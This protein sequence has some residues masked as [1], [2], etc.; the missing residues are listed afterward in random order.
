MKTV[1][2]AKVKTERPELHF[3]YWSG[4]GSAKRSSSSGSGS[5]RTG[6]VYGEWRG[7]RPMALEIDYGDVVMAKDH[8]GDWYWSVIRKFNYADSSS[9]GTSTSGSAASAPSGRGKG[10]ILGKK[11]QLKSLLIHFVGIG[12]EDEETIRLSEGRL[13]MV[14]RSK[15][16]AE[17]AILR[18]NGIDSEDKRIQTL[19]IDPLNKHE[20]IVMKEPSRTSKMR[21]QH[22]KSSVSLSKSPS[23]SSS[24]LASSMLSASSSRGLP[25]KERAGAIAS[26][27]ALT[28]KTRKQKRK[29]NE[30]SGNSM[31]KKKATKTKAKKKRAGRASTLNASAE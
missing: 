18:D 19:A 10:L 6:I 11:Q 24:S 23:P 27:D 20:K 3:F 25:K 30:I 2:E 1:E 21:R 9:S 14:D 26:G 31:G 15:L 16:Q 12:I 22:V 5:T 8:Q 17:C 28:G 4:D 29:L 7:S 13:R